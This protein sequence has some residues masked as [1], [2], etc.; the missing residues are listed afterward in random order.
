[1]Y[2]L[3]F[4]FIPG[5]LAYIASAK[6][7]P[8]RMVMGIRWY[9][10]GIYTRPNGNTGLIWAPCGQGTLHKLGSNTNDKN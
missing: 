2:A 7:Q 6:H 4:P 3:C 1:M 8:A 5:Y 9:P 10:F